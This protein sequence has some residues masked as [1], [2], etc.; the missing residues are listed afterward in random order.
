MKVIKLL[1]PCL[2]IGLF[3]VACGDKDEAVSKNEYE[4]FRDQIGSKDFTGFAYILS[5]YK[6]EE[7]DYLSVI[8]DIFEKEEESLIYTNVQT[9]SDEIS[10]QFNEDSKRKDL[11]LPKDEIAYIQD[12]EMVSNYEVTEDIYTNEGNKE[13]ATFI[14]KHKE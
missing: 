14:R 1:F 9:A 4:E 8:Q 7:E 3:L 11:Y 12:G 2:L 6:A 10:D 13:L 5:D